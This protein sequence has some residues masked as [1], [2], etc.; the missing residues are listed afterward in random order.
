MLINMRFTFKFFSSILIKQF[1]SYDEILHKIVINFYR[2]HLI[3]TL[4]NL[5]SNVIG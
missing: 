3:M 4:E 1:S 2:C 5:V